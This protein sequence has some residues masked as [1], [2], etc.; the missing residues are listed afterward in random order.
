MQLIHK[1][2]NKHPLFKIVL[3][4]ISAIDVLCVLSSFLK[5]NFILAKPNDIFF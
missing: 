1:P 3:V 5:I 2:L 4:L